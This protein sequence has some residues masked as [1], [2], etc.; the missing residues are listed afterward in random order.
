MA[1]TLPKESFVAI[2]AVGWADGWMKK[3]ESEG[4]LRAAKACGVDGDSL[5]EVESAVKNGA[6]LDELDVSTLN[7]WQ[8]A[9][10]YAIATWLARLDG[11]VNAG[12]LAHLKDLGSA[13]DLPQQKLDAAASAAFDIACLPGGHRP[14][15]YDFDALATRLREKL[16]SLA[17]G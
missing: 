15:K 6:S 13:L 3:T 10:T 17:Q 4:L 12:E 7:G 16:P 14:E 11:V 5:G 8:R 2:A 1:L 9:L